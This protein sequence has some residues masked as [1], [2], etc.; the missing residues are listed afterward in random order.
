MVPYK[1]IK[2]KYWK[3]QAQTRR[4]RSSHPSTKGQRGAVRRN[5]SLDMRGAA[6][7][8][9]TSP[10]EPDLLHGR[11]RF[12][13]AYYCVLFPECTHAELNTFLYNTTPPCEEARFYDP[14]TLER[15]RVF[16]GCH[17]RQEDSTTTAEPKE[18]ALAQRSGAKN[19]E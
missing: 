15:T 3:V 16:L 9:F 13:L 2:Q 10:Q 19:D 11:A 17:Q 14:S 8:G 18:A 6:I 1:I 4:L 12:R 7:Q 5:L